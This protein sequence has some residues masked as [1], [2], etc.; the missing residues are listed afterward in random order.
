MCPADAVDPGRLE[1]REV[2]RIE[3]ADGTRH[4][5]SV[6]IIARKHYL[7][8][9]GAGYPLHGH[10]EGPLEDLAIVDLTTLQ[11]RAE[12]YEESRRRMIGERIP[13]AEPVTRDD[14]EHRLRTIGRAKAGC[15]DD[16][17]RELQVT[18]QFEELAD[19]I[20]L[21]KAK[22]QWILNEE[23]FRL[24]SNRDPEM[25]DIWVADVASP[26]CLARPRPQDFDPDPR[27][28]RRRS[29]LPPEAR[30]DPFG[31]HNVLKAMKQLGLKARIDRLGDPPHLRGHILVKM[32]IKG[33]AQ[34][35]A[36]A[37]RDDPA[38]PIRWRLVWDGNESKAGLRRHRAAVATPEYAALLAALR[39]GLAHIQGELALS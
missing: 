28:R 30:S 23:R 12:V 11:T 19:R 4:T 35:V 3:L 2:I 18:R 34:F 37:E 25:R 31:L 33:R 16:W 26:S 38:N 17:S 24:R 27:T 7:V 32:P 9:R 36:M 29:P 13:G 1:E 22:R 14:I 20:G 15:G 39:H 8:C 5:G 10:V 21:A 6:T